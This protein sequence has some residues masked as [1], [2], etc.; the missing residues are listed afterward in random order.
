MDTSTGTKV[1][2]VCTLLIPKCVTNPITM[3]AGC[4]HAMVDN[5]RALDMHWE[6]QEGQLKINTET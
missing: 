5:G 1:N 3:H 6:C 4:I 2:E